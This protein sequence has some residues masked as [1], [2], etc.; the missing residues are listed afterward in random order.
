M[1]AP[2]ADHL[3][4]I[5]AVPTLLQPLVAVVPLQVFACELA[6]ARGTR[7]TS[8][9][10][11]PSP[12]RWSEPCSASGPSP[13]VGVGIDVAEIGEF[14][15]AP[16]A[17]PGLANGVFVE[18]ETDPAEG[19]DSGRDSLAAR[20]AAQGGASR[21]CCVDSRGLPWHDC[22]V[23]RGE[24]GQPSLRMSGTV[25]RA[26]DALG[27]TSWQLSL[28][29]D[30]DM[31]SPSS[32]R[33][34]GAGVIGPATAPRGTGR[35]ARPAPRPARRRA[36]AAATAWPGRLRQSLESA[37]AR[38]RSAGRAARRL[39]QQRRRRAVGGRA[40][41]ARAAGSTP[42]RSPMRL[43]EGCRGLRRRAAACIAGRTDDARGA[44]RG[45]ISS[46]TE[47]S[48]S[49]GR[50]ASGRG[51]ARRGPLRAAV[52]SRSTCRAGC[53]PTRDRAAGAAVV[54]D[55][56][57]TFGRVKPGL[58]LAPGSCAPG[59]CT[60]STSD[61]TFRRAGSR[62]RPSTWPA[63]VAGA[64]QA[65]A[66][67]YRRG[68]VGRG[69]VGALSGR[70]VARDGGGPPGQCGNGS[71]RGTAAAGERRVQLPGRRHRVGARVAEPRRCVG[72]RPGLRATSD[73]DDGTGGASQRD[74]RWCSTRARLR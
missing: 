71:I 11:S 19:S 28:S 30:G 36:D 50:A 54:A 13:V 51:G 48:G 1:V 62:R 6:T 26:A 7:S 44:R 68:V 59:R 33:A 17:S 61:W 67:K 23:V 56:T 27:V 45:P 72:V 57:V 18:A 66:Y 46:S 70:R 53:T 41:A 22:E 4:R 35:R 25:R 2:Y 15:A 65:D 49:A 14:G 63:W 9:A 39:G 69:R 16:R 32:S 42:S 10:T 43:H 24:H 3:I 31:A 55:V 74:C 20:W 73:A 12:S 60:S 52:R 40:L 58:V 8:R 5:P 29:H 47:S 37:A 21:R 34:P 64:A 38:C